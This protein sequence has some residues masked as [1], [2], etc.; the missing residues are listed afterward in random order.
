MSENSTSPRK[1]VAHKSETN[2]PMS[3]STNKL[4][5]VVVAES[6]AQGGLTVLQQHGVDITSCVGAT[7]AEL[8]VA[9][10]NAQGLIVRSQTRVDRELLRAAD[11]LSVI[12]RAGVGVDAIDVAA[13]T[14]A[15]VVVVN[16]PSANTLAATEHTFALMLALMRHIPQASRS[17]ADGVWE[18]ARY[19]GHELYGKTLGIVGLGRIGGSVAMRARAFGMEILAT[20]PFVSESRAKAHEVTLIPLE[21]LLERSDIVTLHVPLSV[22]SQRVIDAARIR[23]MKKNAFLVN[24]AR[25]DLVDEDALLAALDAELLAG[26]A[27]DVFSQEPPR[28]GST[29]ARLLRHKKVVAT[30]HLGGSTHEALGRI[31]VELALDV[32]N[33]LQG[34]PAEGAVNAP[35]PCGVDA[36]LVRPFVDVAH[37]LGRLF[38]QLKDEALLP[39]LTMALQGD[40]AE[41]EAAPLVSAFLSGLLQITTERRVSIVNADAIA[42]ELGMVVEVRRDSSR[43]AYAAAIRVTGGKRSLTGTSAH[44]GARVVEIDGY[45]VDTVPAG[46]LILTQHRDVPGMVGRVGTILGDAQINISGMQVSRRV[47]GAKAIMVLSVDRSTDTPTLDALAR[48]PGMVSVRPLTL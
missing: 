22:Q 35:A 3:A 21:E 44:D 2:A 23:K 40:I 18:R 29:G 14:D 17:A 13:A 34:N 33:V 9:V 15:G 20:D 32:V 6:F 8:L 41:V 1:T 47:E 5:R 26:A 30:P 42:R 10:K 12:G 27:M 38:A 46:S 16:T 24:C 36:H 28:A 7:R 37:R 43:D 25:G 11:N 19:V 48:I 4:P 31:A 39:V 45:E